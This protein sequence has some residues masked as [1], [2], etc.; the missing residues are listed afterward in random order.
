MTCSQCPKDLIHDAL[1]SMC[2]CHY[3]SRDYTLAK[4]L[5]SLKLKKKKNVQMCGEVF[6]PNFPESICPS[7]SSGWGASCTPAT[8]ILPSYAPL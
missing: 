1:P 6:V 8:F 7:I 2:F 5:I 4:L 3:V